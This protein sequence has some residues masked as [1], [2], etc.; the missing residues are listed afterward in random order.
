MT[1]YIIESGAMLSLLYVFLILYMRKTT[2]FKLNRLI[3]IAGTVLCLIMPLADINT[4]IASESPIPLI[5]ITAAITG[6]EGE[7]IKTPGSIGYLSVVKIIYWIGAA[8]VMLIT[9]ISLVHTLKAIKEANPEKKGKYRIGIA[10]KPSFSFL[11]FL[12][13]NKNDYSFYPEIIN[14]EMAHINRRHSADLLFFSVITILHWYNPLIWIALNELKMLHEYE[15]DEDVIKQGTD[16]QKYQ[17]LLVKKAVGTERFQLASSFNHSKL[18]KRIMM[19]QSKKT[20]KWM[21]LSYLGLIPAMLLGF[22][23]CSNRENSQSDKGNLNEVA[24]ISFKT[25]KN[26]SLPQKTSEENPVPFNEIESKPSFDGGDINNFSKWVNGQ[27]VYPKSAK[28]AG[29]QGKVTVSFKVNTDGSVSDI[30]I[31]EGVCSSIDDEVIRVINLS[32]KWTPGKKKNKEVACKM[33]LLVIFM[34]N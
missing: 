6:T 13:I 21:V 1:A 28:D 25:E 9:S 14:H 29:V 15:A 2:F 3:F 17:L 27:L 34:L 26:D 31:I 22:C 24:V 19:M 23:F 11:N 12:I 7:I 32:P 33:L 20:N 18:K 4:R 10:E 30:E 8:T 5:N 16:A